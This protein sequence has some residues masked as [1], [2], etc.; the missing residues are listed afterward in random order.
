MSCTLAMGRKLKER[1][2]TARE[3]AALVGRE[4]STSVVCSGDDSSTTWPGGVEKDGATTG[5]SGA[6]E[7]WI[8]SAR[9]SGAAGDRTSAES[10]AAIPASAFS[11]ARIPRG[12]EASAVSN[13]SRPAEN[14]RG[15]GIG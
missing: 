6:A 15:M 1:S 7:R 12:A 10:G 3:E 11:S 14:Q 9:V 4:A 8:G 13:K 5:A 2:C